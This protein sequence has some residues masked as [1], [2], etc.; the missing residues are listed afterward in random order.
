MTKRQPEFRAE[1][2]EL[3]DRGRV[4]RD[5]RDRSGKNQ[6]LKR[7]GDEAQRRGGR[8]TERDEGV[9]GYRHT[10]EAAEPIRPPR[11]QKGG[12]ITNLEFEIV[13]EEY[14]TDTADELA[15]GM[16]TIRA[17]DN[18]ASYPLLLEA[19]RGA[20]LMAEEFI[21]VDGAIETAESWWTAVT[22]CITR[23]C[24][25]VCT[26][27]LTSCRGTWV[28]YLGCVAWNCGGCWVKCSA[29]ATCNCRWWCKWAAGCCSQ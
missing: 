19:P 6:D 24:A 8:R 3:L 10:F 2:I 13:V 12:T 7:L 4:R 25:S 17:G 21:V 27:S 1:R 16:S 29:C 20:F 26:N 28:E 23:G 9:I 15:V 11:G 14:E 22:G 18:E 5:M